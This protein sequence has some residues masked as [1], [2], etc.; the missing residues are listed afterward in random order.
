MFIIKKYAD[1]TGFFNEFSQYLIKNNLTLN[2]TT[3]DDKKKKKRK[4][5]ANLFYKACITA[6]KPY[7]DFFLKQQC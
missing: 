2:S 3:E 1:S 5:I 7:K 4:G 6:L